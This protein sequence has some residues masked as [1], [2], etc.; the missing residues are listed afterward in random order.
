MTG[1]EEHLIIQ[2][3]PLD[4][5]DTGETQGKTWNEI[6]TLQINTVSWKWF[7]SQFRSE[8]VQVFKSGI[9]QGAEGD[10]VS[11]PSMDPE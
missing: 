7:W 1:D 3:W 8:L 10:N 4:W 9:L 6:T 2:Y 11:G 5:R